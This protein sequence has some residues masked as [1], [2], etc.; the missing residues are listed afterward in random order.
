MAIFREKFLRLSFFVPSPLPSFYKIFNRVHNFTS[1]FFVPYFRT[2]KKFVS[3]NISDFSF[4]NFPSKTEKKKLR[5]I[6]SNYIL[7]NFDFKKRKEVGKFKITSFQKNKFL[8]KKIPHA[9]DFSI[10]ISFKNL[11]NSASVKINTLRKYIFF[12]CQLSNFIC[13]IFK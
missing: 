7:C 4:F 13:K 6:S 8:C 9:E 10:S 5:K 2:T 3:K 11:A 12:S 1:N